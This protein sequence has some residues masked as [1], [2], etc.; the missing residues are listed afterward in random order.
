MLLNQK[1]SEGIALADF[2]A[3]ASV[4]VSTVTTPVWVNVNVYQ[5]M[6]FL[7]ET[8]VLGASATVDAKIRQA[9][10]NAG[11]GAKDVT[12]R[13]ITQIVKATGDNKRAMIN[14]NVDTDLDTTN[15]FAFVQ[16]SITIGTAASIVGADVFGLPE[17]ETADQFNN[18]NV[19]QIVG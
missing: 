4:G 9:T 18:A 14:L 11:T 6:L 19:V 15:G 17:Y 12:G 2:L 5:R 13:A 3:S 10:D 8:G 7:L 1:V 16:L